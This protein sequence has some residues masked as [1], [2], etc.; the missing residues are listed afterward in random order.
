MDGRRGKGD[1]ES[2]ERKKSGGDP[3]MDFMGRG[4]RAALGFEREGAERNERDANKLHPN[5]NI[6]G[7]TTLGGC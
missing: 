5:G 3:E 4:T 6:R 7:L 1:Q 2:R